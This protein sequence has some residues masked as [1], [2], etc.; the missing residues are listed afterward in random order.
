MGDPLTSNQ[1]IVKIFVDETV[2]YEGLELL[3]LFYKSQV[4]RDY[5][6]LH[7]LLILFIEFFG[8]SVFERNID[9]HTTRTV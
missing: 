9:S 5:H 7:L 1:V 4:Y 8:M 2:N 3:E 6:L